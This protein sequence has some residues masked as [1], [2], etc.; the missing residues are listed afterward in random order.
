VA[1]YRSDIRAGLPAG[2]PN[3][4]VV[5]ARDTLG[6]AVGVAG[7]LPEGIGLA[8]LD[9]ARTAFVHGMNV[10]SAV[11]AVMAVVLAV[12][13]TITLRNLE[14]GGAGGT[15]D[16]AES[17]ESRSPHADARPVAVPVAEA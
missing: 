16:E 8:L 5:A 1:I 15:D 3:D 14:P 12:V 17:D 9:V 11:A 2:V 13:A 6:A 7:Q 10:S 4:A